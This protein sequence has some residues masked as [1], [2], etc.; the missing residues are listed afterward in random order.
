[1]SQRIGY[2]GMAGPAIVISVSSSLSSF[3]VFFSFKYR[4]GLSVERVRE[5]Y[6]ISFPLS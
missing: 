1:M 4:R 3:L 5:V 2:S 6:E